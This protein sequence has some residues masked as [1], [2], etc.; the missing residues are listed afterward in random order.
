VSGGVAE[1]ARG[2]WPARRGWRRGAARDDAAGRL[3]VTLPGAVP[4][5]VVRLVP[6]LLVLA[7]GATV[8]SESLAWAVLLGLAALATLR[9]GGLV[10]VGLTAVL[11][12]RLMP[13]GDPGLVLLAGL[14][15]GVHLV[16]ASAGLARHVAWR[17]LVDP[18]ALGR[19]AADLVPVQVVSQALV[20]VAALLVRGAH[21]PSGSL[22]SLAL[23][24]VAVVALVGVLRAVSPR[25]R[26]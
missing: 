15:L 1:R 21:V 14:V 25:R 16:A 26:R 6:P 4:G 24:A 3:V 19:A 11:A 2:A 5:W 12:V 17:A 13:V 23:R 9:P 8:A 10:P 7:V 20:L 22:M 18:A